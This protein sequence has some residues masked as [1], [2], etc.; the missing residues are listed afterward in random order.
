MPRGMARTTVRQTRQESRERIVRAAEQLV[1]RR[2]YSDLTVDELMS[3]AGSGA[4]SST[5]T[6]TTSATC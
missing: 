1:R 6:S 2:S 4:R 3:E 5:A